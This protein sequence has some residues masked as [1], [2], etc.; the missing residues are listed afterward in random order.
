MTPV[1]TSYCCKLE[2]E[3]LEDETEL[4]EELLLLLELLDERLWLDLLELLLLELFEEMLWLELLELLLERLYE[5]FEEELLLLLSVEA[6]DFV[7]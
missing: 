2:D 7:D 3:E 6:E 1:I 4:D 5:L